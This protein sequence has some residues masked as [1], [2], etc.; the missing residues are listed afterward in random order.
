[1]RI[2]ADVNF[3]KR[4]GEAG[5]SD[6]KQDEVTHERA[7]AMHAVSAVP[8]KFARQKDHRR[9][10]VKNVP[11]QAVFAAF[12]PSSAI[13]SSRMTNFCALPVT[14]IGSVGLKR[15]YRGTL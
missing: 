13:I 12:R 6:F 1:M 4:G 14:V 3:F 15:M 9:V 8:G 11:R 10:C 2:A 7:M 5:C